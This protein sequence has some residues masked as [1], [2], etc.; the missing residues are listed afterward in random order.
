MRHSQSTKVAVPS[1]SLALVRRQKCRCEMWLSAHIADPW[2]FRVPVS[3]RR[4]CVAPKN[5][6]RLDFTNGLEGGLCTPHSTLPSQEQAPP[7]SCLSLSVPT[8]RGHS[9]TLGPA[10]STST[11]HHKTHR[12]CPVASARV[13]RAVPAGSLPGSVPHSA[14]LFGPLQSHNW[15]QEARS[16]SLGD[17][18]RGCSGVKKGKHRKRS[19]T[20]QSC[21]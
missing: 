13:P 17:L 1:V 7:S 5:D 11:D 16:L 3:A 15:S 19:D 18:S 9:W 6:Q 10:E 12:C 21:L 14:F 20:P 4:V 8:P 2:H